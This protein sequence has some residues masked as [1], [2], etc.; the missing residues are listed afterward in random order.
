MHFSR[1]VIA[2]SASLLSLGAT[3]QGISFTS[4]PKDIQAGKPVTLKW[5]GAPDKPVTLSLR[6]GNA[7]DLKQVQTITD[8][9]DGGSFTWTPGDNI[10]GGK[11]YAFQISQDGQ[12]NW[13]ALLKA[14]GKPVSDSSETT[15]TT[16]A[17]TTG[18]SHSAETTATTTGANHSAETTTGTT[19]TGHSTSKHLIS[20]SS[21]SASP[22]GSP[23][24][25]TV[26]SSINAN[27][28]YGTSTGSFHNKE[29]TESGSVQTGAASLSRYSATLAV[30]ALTVAAYL[31]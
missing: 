22:S 20:S 27:G 31:L 28:P 17:T 18:A 24:S 3:V 14:G 16:A 6:E 19:T 2:V 4:W 15:Q 8:K 11:S 30:G 26:V 29:A 7:G 23:T 25:T 1:S 13:S 12:S 5:D 10:K 21:V 9:A